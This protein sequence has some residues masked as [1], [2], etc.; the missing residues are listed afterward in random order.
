M[1]YNT[2]TTTSTYTVV[3]IR[4]TFEGFEAD[5]RMIAR[6]TEKWTTEYVDMVFHDIIKLAEAKFLRSVDIVLL[7]SADQPIRAAK[8]TVNE[9]GNSITGD[10]AGGN[11]WQNLLN[12]QL[13]VI[14]SYTSSWHSLTQQQQQNFRQENKFKIGWCASNLDNSFPSLSKQAAQNFASNGYE[15]NKTNYK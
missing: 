3:D 13:S 15:L 8:Y 14:L 1:S 11:D 9:A 4:K 12:T 6:R 2:Y 7:N 5:L 10:R